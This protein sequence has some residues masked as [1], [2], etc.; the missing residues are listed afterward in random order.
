MAHPVVCISRFRGAGGEAVGRIVSNELGFRYVDDEILVRAAKRADVDPTLVADTERRK[1]LLTRVLEMMAPAG[2]GQL[3]PAGG[4]APDALI[5][6]NP[7]ANYQELIGE[8][9]RETG[10]EG[11]TVIVAHAAS[12]TLAGTAGLLRVLVTASPE[13]RAQRLAKAN[14]VSEGDARK[15]IDDSDAARDDYFRRFYNV[16]EELPTHYDLVVNADSLSLAAAA[17]V[18]VAAARA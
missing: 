18:V 6:I 17:D 8:V 5:A 16:S 15:Q 1:S 11:K 10:A 14:G 7:S 12:M 2:A 4:F 13:T 3:D 9:I